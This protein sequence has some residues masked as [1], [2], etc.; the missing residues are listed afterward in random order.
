MFTLGGLLKLC[1]DLCA[2]IGP[3][4][5]QQIVQYIESMYSTTYASWM[6]FNNNN[7]TNIPNATIGHSSYTA[8][9]VRASVGN[10]SY[11][12]SEIVRNR[13]IT[14]G[15]IQ[16]LYSDHRNNNSNS[17]SSRFGN[18]H[19][20]SRIGLQ[21]V[22][23]NWISNALAA[24]LTTTNTYSTSSSSGDGNGNNNYNMHHI[25]GP[26]T[27]ATMITEPSRALSIGLS[28][29]INT[30]TN[31]NNQMLNAGIDYNGAEVQIYYPNWLDLVSNGWAIAWLVLLAALAQGAFS[32]ASTHVLN[33]TGI[34]IKTSLQGLIYRKTLLLNS[35][36]G[37]STAGGGVGHNEGCAASGVV[38]VTKGKYLKTQANGLDNTMAAEEGKAGRKADVAAGNAK[39]NG[40]KT[41]NVSGK[42]PN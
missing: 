36:V 38:D 35:S 12:S 39:C 16:N 14:P 28:S 5:I 37:Q 22:A 1:G 11:D 29:I 3:L 18:F 13:S 33:M 8:R 17:S 4:A 24:T 34:R 19:D 30:S 6:Q 27:V 40:A 21:A 15:G 9:M 10:H 32:Q 31:D 20:S 7:S 41:A 42:L 2:L 25:N 23:T 26:S